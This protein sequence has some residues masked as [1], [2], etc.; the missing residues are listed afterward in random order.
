MLLQTP[1]N[2]AKLISLGVKINAIKGMINKWVFLVWLI[3]FPSLMSALSKTGI[4]TYVSVMN[5][6]I[7]KKLIKIE[8]ITPKLSS[9]W[10]E[11]I[12]T[13]P[14]VESILVAL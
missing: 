11:K 10:C 13:N 9:Q 2:K 12:S 8:I 5:I 4:N 7:L 6:T 1:K 14:L 3:N